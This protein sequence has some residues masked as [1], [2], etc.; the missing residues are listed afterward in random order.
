MDSRNITVRDSIMFPHGNCM[1]VGFELFNNLVQDVSFVRNQCWHLM[2]SA[3]S[4]HDGGHAAVTNLTY[5]DIIVEGL[6]APPN[7]VPHDPSYG[8]KLLDL[9]I[10][11]S[12]CRD[13]GCRC[14]QSAETI[15]LSFSQR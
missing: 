10:I 9:Q 3:M 13:F 4:V 5:R 2:M 14:F 1:E 15:F 7:T 12:H 11:Q 8:Y 6:Y